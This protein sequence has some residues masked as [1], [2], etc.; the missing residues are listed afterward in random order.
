MP[1]IA[2]E[3]AAQPFVLSLDIGSSSIRAMIFDAQA[4]DV[5]MLAARATYVLRATDD[6][7][8]EADA[9]VM[10]AAAAAALDG[11]LAAAGPVA[12]QVAAV[13][14]CSL[15]SN[16]LGVDVT[17]RPTTPVYFWGDTRPAADTAALRAQV[18][19][20]AWHERTG[21]V[22]H[23]SYLA[24]R[25]RW[26]ARTAPDVA[27]RTAYWLSFGEYLYLRL[28]GVRACS[29]SVASWTGLLNRHTLTWD[30]E[31]L[32]ALPIRADQLS[33]LVDIS[34]TL[35]GL[36]GDYAA[37]WPALSTVPWLPT[38]G[39]G[40]TANL[41]SG[42]VAADT[43]ALTI[44]TSAAMR[45]VVPDPV[46]TVPPGLW[47]YRVDRRRALLG[48]AL[49]NGGNLYEWMH[50]TLN[51][52]GLPDLEAAVAALPPDSHGLTVL[53][54]LAGERSP[55][56]AADACATIEGLRL[57]TGAPEILRAGLEAVAYRFALIL[58]G[59]AP[60]V[61][62][63]RHAVASGA[64]LLHSPAW[65]QIHADVLGLP[66]VASAEAE[67]SSRG[68]ALLA[69]EVLGVIPDAAALPAALALVYTPNPAHHAV[70]Q[71]AVA[72][73]QALYA[74]LVQR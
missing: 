46:P 55:G 56:W 70:Y 47:L 29:I 10:L 21:T 43:L 66:V 58:A 19:G 50:H 41:G 14:S 33:P 45:V 63:A 73:Q 49:S 18:D 44:G 60:Q 8:Q 24:P 52:A 48:G 36:R 11:V 53:P 28:F 69:L 40:A 7:G 25:L 23:T 57:A 37:R 15:V 17:G 51:L 64:G 34:D 54:F 13:A 72:R 67:A 62:A 35:R 5:A 2:R 16:L 22:L 71:Q 59:L 9:D 65:L 42:C 6:G 30:A 31:S 68:N 38:V 39:D 61:P 20:V 12:R 74:K 27:A 4:R 26:L 32:A 1:T 3:A